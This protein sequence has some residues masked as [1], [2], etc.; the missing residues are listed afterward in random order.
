MVFGVATGVLVNYAIA[1]APAV[2]VPP[3]YTIS[4]LALALIAVIGAVA[5]AIAWRWPIVGLTAGLLI[6][7]IVVVGIA[8]RWGWSSAESAWLDPLN[9]LAF[10]TATGY[11]VLIGAAMATASGLRLRAG[12]T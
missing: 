6:V 5:I 8:A 11:P 2:R 10:G 1:V 3:N 7:A 9:A 4:P 12:R